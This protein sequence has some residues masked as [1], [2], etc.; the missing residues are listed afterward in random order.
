[1]ALIN[2]DAA[3]EVIGGMKAAR[4]AA[5]EQIERGKT[6]L[7]STSK[8][9]KSRETRQRIMDA[10]SRLIIQRRSVLFQMSEV[11]DLCGMSKGSLYYYF[12]DRDELIAA[13][14]D[15][16]VNGLVE[17]IEGVAA[18][19]ESAR[20]A[21]RGLYGEFAKRLREGSVLAL[22]M[23]NGLAGGGELTEGDVTS[24]LARVAEVIAAQIERA[25]TEGVVRADV[26][27]SWAATY[28]IGGFIATAMAVALEPRAGDTDVD[29]LVQGLMNMTFSGVG[30]PGVS[31]D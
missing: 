26:D 1:M 9:R 7:R 17:Q 28:A 18:R 20:A 25:K 27:S 30:V 6:R 14:F 19:A 13:V 12:S 31:L 2:E 22:A 29:T 15:E 5:Y 3:A 24:R 8:T 11:S 23:T 21:L 4:S 16:S 10:A